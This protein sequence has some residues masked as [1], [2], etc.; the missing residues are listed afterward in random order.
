MDLG[1]GLGHRLVRLSKHAEHN[2]PA[3]AGTSHRA[4][5]ASP[6]VERARVPPPRSGRTDTAGWRCPPSAAYPPGPQ[7]SPSL[8]PR[9]ELST[10]VRK[11]SYPVSI[12]RR[13]GSA[14]NGKPP[15][16]AKSSL[17]HQ[18]ARVALQNV[19][20]PD[21]GLHLSTPRTPRSTAT[22]RTP[23]DPS[24][25]QRFLGQAP[26]DPVA[27]NSL[28][29]RHVRC[30]APTVTAPGRSPHF[31]ASRR[32]IIARWP[33]ASCTSWH[34]PPRLPRTSTGRTANPITRFGSCI[35]PTPDAI[36]SGSPRPPRPDDLIAAGTG[37]PTRRAAPAR[38]MLIAP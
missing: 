34:V 9:R 2:T 27:L 17:T 5:S 32:G 36:L 15:F 3:L 12:P 14:R 21:D 28:P 31:C 10:A 13:S 33:V 29:D 20:Q 16:G 1:Q 7:P 11:E 19:G 8:S 24:A 35:V 37:G 6:P 23:T 30:H 25:P 22:A 38:C 18:I 26:P 4:C